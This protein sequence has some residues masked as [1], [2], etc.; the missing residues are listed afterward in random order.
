MIFKI[1]PTKN[2]KSWSHSFNGPNFTFCFSRLSEVL[3]E[4]KW[5][6]ICRNLSQFK[7]NIIYLKLLNFKCEI[8][9]GWGH[10]KKQD[11]IS[12]KQEQE[13]SSTFWSTKTVQV[14]LPFHV[15]QRCVQYRKRTL[16]GLIS[17]TLNFTHSFERALVDAVVLD[18]TASF[19]MLPPGKCGTFKD[20]RSS[21]S[22]IRDQMS[23][24]KC[25]DNRFSMG[26]LLGE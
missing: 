17:H 26:L 7:N 25:K 15:M 3:I 4:K 10:N 8:I 14:R 9:W 11:L 21:F 12:V 23:H 19:N 24:S 20:C 2:Y 22:P 5:E 1:L 6:L 18:G 13:T 16:Y